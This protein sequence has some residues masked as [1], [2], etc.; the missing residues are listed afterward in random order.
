MAYSIWLMTPVR[1]R[2]GTPEELK[3][4]GIRDEDTLEVLQCS[5]VGEFGEKYGVAHQALAE[6]R[7]EF[8]SSDSGKDIRAFFRPL[9]KEGLGALYQKLLE[10]GD[11][12][13]FKILAAYTEGWVPTVGVQHSGEIG[14]K[15]DAEQKAELDKLLAKNTK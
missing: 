4:M 7:N 15:L 8:E 10:N 5:S 2:G 9:I 12:E 14:N 11:A 1:F 3:K 6:W 13:R